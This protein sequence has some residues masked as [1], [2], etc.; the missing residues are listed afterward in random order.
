M[1][2]TE[3]LGINNLKIMQDSNLFCFGT[4]SVALSDFVRAR[5]SDTV[6]DLCTG[7]GI[8]PILLSAKTKA[9]KIFGVEIQKCS[10]DLAM[11]NVKINS[12]DERITMIH[13]DIADISNHFSAGSVDVVTCNPPYMSANSGFENPNE[14]LAIAR[15]EICTNL[16]GVIDATGKILKFG[17]HFFM[18]HRADRLCDIIWELRSAKMEMK[19]IRFISPAPEKEP[20]LVL[21]EAMKGAMPSL[22]FEPTLYVNV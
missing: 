2:R 19:R 18:V 22:K 15:H 21:V 10:L 17:G 14:S 5:Q 13:A 1:I 6:V 4:D 3:D 7:N 12:L 20:K 16:S 9:K 8:I 11:E